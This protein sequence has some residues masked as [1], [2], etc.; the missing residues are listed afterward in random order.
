MIFGFSQ[1]ISVSCY[2]SI[3]SYW[4]QPFPAVILRCF[5]PVLNLLNSCG[6]GGGR[7]LGSMSM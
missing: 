2:A 4:C 7:E 5:K 6:C 3:S 1:I